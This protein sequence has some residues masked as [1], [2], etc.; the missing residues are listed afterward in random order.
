MRLLRLAAA[1]VAL[2]ARADA[3]T[4]CTRPDGT[5][6]YVPQRRVHLRLVRP[7]HARTSRK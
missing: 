7:T 4:D 6:G 3:Q 1:A 2:A 5:A